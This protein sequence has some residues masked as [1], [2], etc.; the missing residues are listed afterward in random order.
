MAA[1]GQLPHRAEI[2]SVSLGYPCVITTTEVHGFDTFDFIRISNANGLMPVPE[3]GADQLNNNR[4]RIIVTGDDTFKLQDPITF[5]DIDSTNFV[6]YTSGGKVNL[7]EN[8]FYYYGEP[9]DA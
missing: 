2:L 5:Q 8:T 7:I 1:I 9:E 6:P 3:I 4:Y